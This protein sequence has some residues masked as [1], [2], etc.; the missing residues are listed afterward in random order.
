MKIKV[1]NVSTGDL[2]GE[3]IW[4]VCPAENQALKIRGKIYCVSAV[5]HVFDNDFIEVR[6][7]ANFNVL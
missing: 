6:V 5:I 2:L 7:S 1:I 4:G 3:F